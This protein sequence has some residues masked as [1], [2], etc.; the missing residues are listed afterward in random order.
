MTD[1]PV[2]DVIEQ[3]TE[4]TREA[5]FY[6]DLK[7]AQLPVKNLQPGDTL[8]YKARVVSTRAEAANEFWGPG[9][10]SRSIGRRLR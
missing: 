6:S 1:T 3:P 9:I 7:E 2:T 10:V 5:P 4:V 8:E